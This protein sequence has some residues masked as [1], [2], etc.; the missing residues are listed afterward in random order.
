MQDIWIESFYNEIDA[1][2]RQAFLKEH[3][4]DPKDELDEFREK[5]WIARYGKRK[6][7][8]DAF[9]GYLMQ[10]KYIAEGGGMSLGAQKRKQAAEVLTGL[11]LGSYDNLDIEKQEMVFYE[12][13][14][15]F[16]K[17][18]GVSKNGRGFTSVV[19]GMGQL[20]DE[21]VAKKIADQIH[22]I[23]VPDDD[24]LTFN[25]DVEKIVLHDEREEQYLT[26]RRSV[27]YNGAS[28]HFLL[29]SHMRSG[30]R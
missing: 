26:V 13:K 23:N 28:R 25:N 4:G 20:S 24:F 21:S 5:L 15:A 16:L 18:I 6:P 1:E 8:N 2:K 17:L 3:T 10:M 29:T 11:F 19:F 30:L 14:N 7:K 27:R 9:V 22:E 12:I